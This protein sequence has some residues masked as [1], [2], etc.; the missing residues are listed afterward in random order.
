MQHIRSGFLDVRQP[1]WNCTNV[2][3]IWAVSAAS[4]CVRPAVHALQSQPADVQWIWHVPC[5]SL[6]VCCSACDN[7]LPGIVLSETGSLRASSYITWRSSNHMVAWLYLS[8]IPLLKNNNSPFLKWQHSNKH[9]KKSMICV[10]LFIYSGYWL[11][12]SH[13]LISLI[14]LNLKL[15]FILNPFHFAKISCRGS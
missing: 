14:L 3:C 9:D 2:L 11:H 15:Q 1:G 13:G 12:L 6:Q 10:C 7:T 8:L 5:V 4:G